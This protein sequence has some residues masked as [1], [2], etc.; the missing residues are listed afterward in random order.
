M[1]SWEPE[2]DE[3]LKVSLLEIGPRW[4]EIAKRLPGRTEAMCRNRRQRGRIADG[5]GH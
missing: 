2:E 5:S 1:K 4:K 3:I